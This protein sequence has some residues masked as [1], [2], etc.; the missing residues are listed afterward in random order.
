MRGRRV[1]DE[2]A[3]RESIRLCQAAK[4]LHIPLNFTIWQVLP[5]MTSCI[6]CSIRILILE[7]CGR[8]WQYGDHRVDAHEPAALGDRH[9]VR[10]A[11][12]CFR[13]LGMNNRHTA[14][15]GLYKAVS[16]EHIL[17]VRMTKTIHNMID[18]YLEKD[19]ICVDAYS[20]QA[21]LILQHARSI[22]CTADLM[23][24]GVRW[25][26]A[27]ELKQS[28]FRLSCYPQR[29]ESTTMWLC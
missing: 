12:R 9:I 21:R 26:T 15:K 17:I 5:I 3:K 6:P 19:Y 2:V 25:R 22:A 1:F 28:S 11:L 10:K 7:D 16:E 29:M 23:L 24:L 13:A 18:E 20:E 27:R 4:E 14:L 8:G